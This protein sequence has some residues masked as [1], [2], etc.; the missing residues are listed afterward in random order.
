MTLWRISN[1]ASL[2]GEG[3]LRVSARW[4]TRGTRIVYCART[5]AAALLEVLV[6]FELDI[7]NLP[8]SYRLLQIEAP[9]DLVVEDL[10]PDL[11]SERW[12]E[13]AAETRL[14]GDTWLRAGSTALMAVPSAIVPDTFNILVNPD[15]H[16]ARRLSIVRVADHPI[17]ARLLGRDRPERRE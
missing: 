12:V 1:H 8:V 13:N 11:L 9:R 7:T 4:H 14:F 15:H 16:D 5:P 3:G 6:H 2:S 17:D 10:P